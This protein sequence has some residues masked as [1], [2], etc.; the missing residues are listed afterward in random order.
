[1]AK[2]KRYYKLLNSPTWLELRRK[3]LT[4]DPL[5]ENCKKKGIYRMAQEIHHIV[6]VESAKDYASMRILAY[7]YNNLM[8]LCSICHHE[9]HNEMGSHKHIK[10]AM[11]RLR[12]Y[13]ID[14]YIKRLFD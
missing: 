1:M 5:C 6:P 8:S 11:T 13:T 3:K 14:E 10:E 9:I 2:D 12:D 7:D 4:V